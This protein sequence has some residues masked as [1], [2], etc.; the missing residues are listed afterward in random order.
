[1]ELKSQSYVV[2]WIW[3]MS[4][5]SNI[6]F[7]DVLAIHSIVWWYFQRMCHYK[8]IRLQPEEEFPEWGRCVKMPKPN[9]F[10]HHA[11]NYLQHTVKLLQQELGQRL[12]WKIQYTYGQSNT[13]MIID[14]SSLNEVCICA[15]SISIFVT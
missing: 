15:I 2:I 5:S 6:L 4:L 9:L 1:M 11:P 10:L 3:M 8:L 13:P 7:W 14:A 12:T